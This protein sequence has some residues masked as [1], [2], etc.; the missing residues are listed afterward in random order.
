[1]RNQLIRRTTDR[2]TEKD[3]NDSDDTTGTQEPTQGG[4]GG[5]PDL[6]ARVARIETKLDTLATREELLA[7]REELKGEIATTREELKGEISTVREELKGEIST[8]REELK[9]EISTVRED[10]AR[11][12]AKLETFAT[13][14]DLQAAISTQTRWLVGIMIAFAVLIFTAFSPGAADRHT[15]GIM[16]DSDGKPGIEEPI[17]GVN[18]GGPAAPPRRGG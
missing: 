18:G 12:E 1:M 4:D 8:T 13:R 11:V 15:E 7:T 5:G 6:G 14:E 9:G 17:Q 10:L 16:D 3:M 2:H